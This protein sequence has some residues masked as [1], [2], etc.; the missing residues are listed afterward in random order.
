M[1]IGAVLA[2]IAPT[3]MAQP[4]PIIDMHF[5]ALTA[6]WSGPPGSYICAPFDEWPARDPAEPIS[7]YLHNFTGD[8]KCKQRLKSP[9]TDAE[10]RDESLSVLKKRNIIAV[11]SGPADK[12]EDFRRQ[13]PDRIIPGLLF[14]AGNLPTIGQLRKLHAEGRLKVLG[15]LVFQYVGI[16]PDDP[17]IEPYYALAEELDIPVAIHIGPGPPGVSYFQFPKYR[18]RLSDP[19][20][21]EDV[22]TRHPKLRIDVM[23]AGWPMGD[24][25]IALM[26]AHPQVYVDTGI[27]DYALPRA[28]FHAY[29]KRLVDAGFQRRI[30]FGSDQMNWPQAIDA[31]IEG[32]TNAKFLTPQQKRDILYNNAA[33]FLRLNQQKQMQ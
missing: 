24:R 4:A 28:E 11:A 1:F 22:L 30:M 29:L 25:M 19:L 13:A 3:A 6:D 33:R 18:M 15:E 20:A 8:P 21:L 26:Y 10:L 5:H 17:R 14:G 2:L 32:I 16:A 23:H 9:L 12:V 27:I 31:A 7:T